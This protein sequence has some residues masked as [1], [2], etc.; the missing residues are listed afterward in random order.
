MAD[1]DQLSWKILNAT[2]DDCENLEEIY[3]Q[4]HDH[5]SPGKKQS[6]LLCAVADRIEQLVRTGLLMVEMDENGVPWADLNDTTFVWRAWFRM[7]PEGRQSWERSE[8]A[9]RV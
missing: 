1:L 8:L 5:F 9:H 4:V 3:G 2:A 7:T 6:R